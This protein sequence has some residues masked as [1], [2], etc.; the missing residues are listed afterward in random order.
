[1]L[2]PEFLE[3]KSLEKYQIEAFAKFISLKEMPNSYNVK[4]IK[5]V[6]KENMYNKRYMVK[7][8]W[9]S[10]LI[11]PCT[12]KKCYQESVLHTLSPDQNKDHQND[13][14]VIEK[15]YTP[16]NNDLPD[17]IIKKT[18]DTPTK[19]IKKI[20][21]TPNKI[22]KKTNKIKNNDMLHKLNN[23]DYHEDTFKCKELMKLNKYL[24]DIYTDFCIKIHKDLT[25]LIE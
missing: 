8:T 20:N 2:F 17:K 14:D 7:N 23:I 11:V 4:N 3:Q 18:N 25:F 19:I 21:N 24:D 6:I 12:I 15:A 16:P 22:V 13:P 1:M 10:F 5:E 9:D